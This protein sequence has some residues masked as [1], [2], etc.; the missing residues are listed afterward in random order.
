MAKWEQEWVNEAKCLTREE[1]DESYKDLPIDLE[2][3]GI[4]LAAQAQKT[5][6]N[7]LFILL[8][9]LTTEFSLECVSFNQYVRCSSSIFSRTIFYQPR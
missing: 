3:R 8:I 9:V 1:Y 7:L 2:N 5:V 6:S 4:V